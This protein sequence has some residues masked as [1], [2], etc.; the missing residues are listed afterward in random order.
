MP[1]W[2]FAHC[3]TA[4]KTKLLTLTFKFGKIAMMAKSFSLNMFMCRF[5]L[6]YLMIWPHCYNIQPNGHLRNT[7]GNQWSVVRFLKTSTPSNLWVSHGGCGGRGGGT[8]FS[9]CHCSFSMQCLKDLSQR[10]VFCPSNDLIGMGVPSPICI[11]AP[12][13]LEF[14]LAFVLENTGMWEIAVFVSRIS[15]TKPKGLDLV[16]SN[17]EEQ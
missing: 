7:K 14:G 11:N 2:R 16:H 4:K 8:W 3:A 13:Y 1:C 5:S 17:M 6:D 15:D 9:V 12:Q 10:Q